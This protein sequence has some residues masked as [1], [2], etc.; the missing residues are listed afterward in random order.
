ME[1]ERITAEP[2]AAALGAEVSDV[3]LSKPVDD[4]TF[5]EITDA[6]MKY[7]VLFFRDQDITV[8]DQ[9]AFAKRYGELHVHPVLHQMKDQGHPEVAVLQSNAD[10]PFVAERWHSDVTFEKVP[11]LGSILRAVEVPEKGGD[12][13]WASM[14][15]AYDALSDSMQRLLSSLEA[16]HDGGGFKAVATDE[17]RKTLEQDQTA[18]HPVIRT[19]P[20]TGRK[21][22]FVNSTFTKYIVGMKRAESRAI[23]SFLYDHMA[24]PEFTCRFR[25]RKNSIAMWDNRCT[26]HRVIADNLKDLRRMERITICGDGPPA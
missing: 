16:Y 20:V 8:D 13:M 24:T 26:Q 6:W 10:Q 2:L 5:D 11:P 22:I 9:K 3:D 23:L 17:Q 4:S 18:I 1:Y 15:A 21:T 19:H 25:W 12:T 14:Y 7:Q